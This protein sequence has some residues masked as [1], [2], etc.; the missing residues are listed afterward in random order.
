MRRVECPLLLVK[1]PAFGGYRTI[2]AAVD[3]L[4]AHD[5]PYG[6]DRGVLNAGRSIAQICGSTLRVVYAYQGSES[7][8]VNLVRRS[9]ARCFL[10][11]RERR[12][13][14]QARRQAAEVD[15]VAGSSAPEVIID[16]VA[17]R[18]AQLVVIGMPRRRG[19]LPV[20]LGS[21]AEYVVTSVECDVL[22]VPA[23]GAAQR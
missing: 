7:I 2:V 13:A 12:G 16:S 22:I 9:R 1:S 18:R 6:L 14:S 23:S 20:A 11:R 5:E 19:A 4:H 10:R 8:R 17:K 15:L 21:T 3:P